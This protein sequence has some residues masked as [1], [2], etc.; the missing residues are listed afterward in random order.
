[1]L[2]AKVLRGSKHD[3]TR[4]LADMSGEVVEAIVF[5]ADS[6]GTQRPVGGSAAA[7][8][9]IFAE[10]DVHAVQRGSSDASRPGLYEAGS[11]E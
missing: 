3:I 5:I 9:D 10:M 6:N 7:T 4:R 8:A 11:E 1:M 2:H